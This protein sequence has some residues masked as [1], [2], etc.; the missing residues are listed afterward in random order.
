MSR[1]QTWGRGRDNA[2]EFQVMVRCRGDRLIGASVGVPTDW[3]SIDLQDSLKIIS[4]P[5]PG[6]GLLV[7]F[8]A[9]RGSL[10]PYQ[11]PNHKDGH[12]IDGQRLRDAIAR[13]SQPGAPRVRGKAPSIDVVELT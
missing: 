9:E 8:T 11:C 5:G 1:R 2:A 6:A 7:A 13:L 12:R 4:R 10:G 3:P